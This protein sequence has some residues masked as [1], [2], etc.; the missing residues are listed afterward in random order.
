MTKEYKEEGIHMLMIEPIKNS[1]PEGR[2][3][4]DKLGESL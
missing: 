1:I 3:A 2:E 4:L